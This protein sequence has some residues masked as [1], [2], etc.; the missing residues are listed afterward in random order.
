[1]RELARSRKQLRVA[2]Q[3][4]VEEARR[5]LVSVAPLPAALANVVED[6]EEVESQRARGIAE[7]VQSRS[8]SSSPQ[9]RTE[10]MLLKEPARLD[11]DTESGG[12]TE[13]YPPLRRV[14]ESRA[15]PTGALHGRLRRASVSTTASTDSLVSQAPNGCPACGSKEG[16]TALWLVGD[17][18]SSV[19]AVCGFVAAMRRD[20]D[21]A[22]SPT[23]TPESSRSQQD[24]A[25]DAAGGMEVEAASESLDSA[26]YFA[27]PPMSPV[28]MQPATRRP[29]RPP[30]APPRLE[31]RLRT[32]DSAPGSVEEPESLEEPQRPARKRKR[33]EPQPPSRRERKPNPRYMETAASSAE[34]DSDAEQ[35]ESPEKEEV[36]YAAGKGNDND[37]GDDDGGDNNAARAQKSSR[38]LDGSHQRSVVLGESD[39]LPEYCWRRLMRD[40]AFRN[41]IDALRSSK[42]HGRVT[43]GKRVVLTGTFEPGQRSLLVQ[44]VS[45][46]GGAVCSAVESPSLRGQSATTNEKSLEEW[47]QKSRQIVL[48]P[49]PATTAKFLL[50]L[51]RCVPILH[52]NWLVHSVKVQSPLPYHWYLLSASAEGGQPPQRPRSRVFQ[53]KRIEIVGVAE[54]RRDWKEILTAAGA[55]VVERLDRFLSFD[56]RGQNVVVQPSDGARFCIDVLLSDAFPN[57]HYFNYFEL[58][59]VPVVTADWAIRSIVADELVDPA[60]CS[61]K[62]GK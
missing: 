33:P 36:Q 24:P 46:T 40:G 17:D 58:L 41:H 6:I 16:V 29:S 56:S 28:V 60:T 53:G 57:D 38:R 8:H 12:E 44:A 27:D 31:A 22:A 14:R 49:A 62:F 42:G 10:S 52:T 9:P 59:P 50:A 48:A 47:M 25:A 54:F 18:G 13:E 3:L 45:L 51:V 20:R 4:A 30:R 2:P 26:D 32:S 21:R 23:A 19:C 34:L 1:M 7:A 5:P 43:S 11:Y 35:E 39:A 61:P 15:L 37:D 55:Q